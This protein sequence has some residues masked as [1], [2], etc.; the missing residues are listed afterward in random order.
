MFLL[1][2][3]NVNSQIRTAMMT[4]GAPASALQMPPDVPILFQSPDRGPAARYLTSWIGCRRTSRPGRAGRPAA[5]PAALAGTRGRLSV[6]LLRPG[7]RV[8]M[9]APGAVA[10][11]GRARSPLGMGSFRFFPCPA[12]GS[13]TCPYEGRLCSASR[14][15]TG[16]VARTSLPLDM[17]SIAQFALIRVHLC[18]SVVPNQPFGRHRSPLGLGF[19]LRFRPTPRGRV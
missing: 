6:V 2:S 15:F 8:G 19:I 5:R 1:C 14:Q 4:A 9:H 12:D 3:R 13:E 10:S 7:G 11:S 17:A 16:L 18:P